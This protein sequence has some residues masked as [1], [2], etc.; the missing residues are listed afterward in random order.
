MVVV[1]LDALGCE[2]IVRLCVAAVW[3]LFAVAAAVVAFVPGRRT[4]LA[5]GTAAAG[6][7]VAHALLFGALF[8]LEWSGVM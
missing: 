5:A 6:L 3:S 8:A 1:L 4:T 2:V 7:A